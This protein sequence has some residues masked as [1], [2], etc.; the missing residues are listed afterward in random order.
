MEETLTKPEVGLVRWVRS[1][2]QRTRDAIYLWLVTGDDTLMLYEFNRH[3]QI[4]A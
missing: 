1:L 4:A 2:D 3:L